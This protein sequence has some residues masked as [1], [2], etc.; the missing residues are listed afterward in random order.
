M[1][2]R[3]PLHFSTHAELKNVIGQDL[4]NDDNIAVVELVKNSIDAGAFSVVISF[5]DYLPSGS[6]LSGPVILIEDDGSGMGPDDVKDKWLNIAYSEKKGKTGKGRMLAGNK[7]VGRFACDRLGGRLDMFTRRRGLGLVHL[8][9]D[10]TAFES[11]QGVKDTIQKVSVYQSAATSADMRKQLG[12]TVGATGTVLA[13]SSLRQR[14]DRDK[15]RQL[16]RDLQRFVNPIAAFDKSGV[17]IKLRVPALEEPDLR[18]PAYDR[19]NGVIENQVFRTLKFRTS[20]IELVLDTS[21]RH[22]TTELFHDGAR[23]YRLV[24]ETD[25]FAPLKGVGVVLHYMNSYKKA[26]FKRQTGQHLVDFGSVFLF[27]NGYRIAPYGDRDNDWLKLDNRKA[28]GTGR[29]LGVRE[30]LGV[31]DVR[32]KTTQLRVVSNREGVVRND[33]YARLTS[34]DGLAYTALKRLER[35]VVSG[36]DWDTVPDHLRQKLNRGEIPGDQAMPG[37]EVYDLS[38]DTKRR[39]IALDLVR[40]VGASVATAKEIDID[41]DLLDA[42]AQEREDDI[43]EILESFSGFDPK[44][45]G[46][47]L[48]AALRKV[49]GEFSRQRDALEKT[50]LAASRKDRQVARLKAV[51]RGIAKRNVDLERQVSTQHSE[52]L[53]AR[54]SAGSDHDQLLLLHHQA[55]IYARTSRNFLEKALSQLRNGDQNKAREFVERALSATVRAVTVTDFA[56]KANFRMKT[57]T[58]TGDIAQYIQEY[59]VNVAKDASAQRLAVS[60]RRLFEEPFMMRFKPIDLAIVFDN[61]A[62]NSTRAGAKKFDVVMNLPTENELRIDVADDGSGLSKTVR[63][64]ESVFERGVTTTNG[65]GLGLYHVRETVAE[66][67]GSIHLVDPEAAGFRLSIRLFK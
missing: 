24:E 36:L 19:V 4:I 53:F 58:M 30:V 21:G 22:L 67:G 17:E 47:D 54:L 62:S 5:L 20:Y 13:I 60:V 49:E 18:V 6:N 59:L 42:L 9:V 46:K 25:E 63:P 56:T 2:T 3:Q 50:T 55:G 33:A 35:F 51:A 12:L 40:I 1:T 10:W 31:I 44:V 41:P 38:A 16:R 37:G 27:V 61:L 15:L 52:I 32:D 29:H 66:M 14:W 65:S 57:G 11:K 34:T 26:Y 39:R 23:V 7:G 43:K 64:P 45:V 28:Q 48:R 8:E